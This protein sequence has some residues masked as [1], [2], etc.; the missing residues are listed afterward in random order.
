MSK[1]SFSIISSSALVL[2]MGLFFAA[3]TVSAATMAADCATQ[4]KTM[5]AAKTIP[6]GMTEAAFATKCATD[7]AAKPADTAAA[8]ATPPAAAPKAMVAK[9][10]MKK[11]MKKVKPVVAAPDAEAAATAP[12]EPTAAKAAMA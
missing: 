1:S 12:A 7:A 3:P 10:K 9:A 6:A 8:V 5:E 2:S 4:W 11:V